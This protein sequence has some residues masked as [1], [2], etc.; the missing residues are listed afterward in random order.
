MADNNR[1]KGR[2]CAVASAVL[3]A[4][5]AAIA[6]TASA[7][8]ASMQISTGPA[9]SV[10]L[11]TAP[12][13]PAIPP[14]AGLAINR[15]TIPMADYIAAK[16]AA[17]ARAPGQAKPGAAPPSAT[18]VTLYAQ[19]GS[20]NETQTTGGNLFPPGGDIATS[21]EWMVQ[22]NNDVITM[23]DWNTNAFV[24]KKLSTFFQDGTYFIFDPRVIWDPYWKRFVVLADGCTFCQTPS[25][26]SVFELAASATGDPSGSW[27]ISRFGVATGTGDFV[28][29]PQLGMDMNSLIFTYNDFKA[30]NSFDARAFSFAKA[31]QYNGLG[32]TTNIFTGG[33]CTIAPPYVI[34]NSGIDYL[35]QFCPGAPV[36]FIGSMRDTGL[37]TASVSMVDNDVTVSHYGIPP[38]AQQPAPNAAYPL[39]TGDNRF[40]NRSLQVGNRIINTATIAIY[41]FSTPSWYIFDLS[42]SPYKT[43]VS[44][45]YFYASGSLV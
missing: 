44:E 28:D 8:D 13:V 31:L 23:Y 17:A 1:F 30:D 7:Q 39:D 6:P 24:Q 22:V 15:P 10:D 37:T 29:F 38:Q 36:V 5:S 20:T 35:L 26:V 42:A 33:Y 14:P 40:E 12:E 27:L 9:K 16:N 34:D 4:V 2:L 19:V 32:A 45:G 18:G 3:L 11:R 41:S 21:A 43:L 25:N